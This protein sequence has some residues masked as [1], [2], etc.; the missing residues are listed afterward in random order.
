MQPSGLVHTGRGRE[1]TIATA[2]A[3]DDTTGLPLAVEETHD[4]TCFYELKRC[5]KTVTPESFRSTQNTAN[6]SRLSRP[7]IDASCYFADRVVKIRCVPESRKKEQVY[8]VKDLLADDGKG[9]IQ[10]FIATLN[11]ITDFMAIRTKHGANVIQESL[12]V[13]RDCVF[14]DEIVKVWAVLEGESAEKL[15]WLSDLVGDKKHEV[16]DVLRSNSKKNL[17]P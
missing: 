2:Q 4:R 11:A 9:E 1:L 7:R 6:A 8:C 15:Y 13:D 17:N 16:H 5:K 14:K 12:R 3:I 10:A